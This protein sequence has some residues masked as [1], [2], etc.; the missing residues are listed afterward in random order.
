M[1]GRKWLLKAHQRTDFGS[2]CSRGLS[3][4][5]WRD[6]DFRWRCAARGGLWLHQQHNLQKRQWKW[7]QK[8][9]S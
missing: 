6:R 3:R 8:W 9:K 2:G 4:Q 1:G 7:R 5:A